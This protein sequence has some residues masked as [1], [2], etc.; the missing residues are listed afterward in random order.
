[1]PFDN[2][3]NVN[4]NLALRLLLR[5]ERRLLNEVAKFKRQAADLRTSI[6]AIAL[7]SD[8]REKDN[9]ATNSFSTAVFGIHN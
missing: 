8:R 6:D 1:M 2:A 3:R 5:E 9:D 4:F 7:A